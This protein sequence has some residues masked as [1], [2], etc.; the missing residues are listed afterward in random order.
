[1]QEALYNPDFLIEGVDLREKEKEHSFTGVLPDFKTIFESKLTVEYVG[2][3]SYYVVKK[4]PSGGGFNLFLKRSFDIVFSVFVF[5]FV[6]SW[7]IPVLA[8]LIKLDSRG[9]VF[10]RQKRTGRNNKIFSCLKFRTMSY[11]K[12]AEFKAAV[13]NDMRVTKIGRILRKTSIDEFPQFLN[14]LVGDMSVVG[15]RPHPLKLNADFQ[16]KVDKY[17]LRHVVKPG[18][19]GLAQANGHRGEVCD[20]LTMKQRIKIDI[21]YIENWTFWLDIKI[22]FLT[23]YN[24]FQNDKNAY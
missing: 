7:L 16:N 24:L 17:T 3:S 18:V 20:T 12:N 10:Y 8:I 5:V 13:R 2:G 11:S 4:N 23:V 1:M 21:F 9:P 6:L 14:V 15:P 22:V 19:T